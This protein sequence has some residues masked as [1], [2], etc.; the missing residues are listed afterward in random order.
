M[1]AARYQDARA[2]QSRWRNTIRAMRAIDGSSADVSAFERQN[3]INGV[4]RAGKVVC[5]VASC[6]A[7]VRGKRPSRTDLDEMFAKALLIFGNGQLYGAILTE[8]I[9]ARIRVSPAGDLLT[10]RQILQEILRPGVEW[11]TQRKYSEAA[12]SYGSPNVTEG[13]HKSLDPALRTS[14]EAEYRISVEALF[15]LLLALKEIAE[16]RKQ[17]VPI[18]SRSEIAFRLGE[19]ATARGTDV[20]PF[21]DRLTLPSREGWFDLSDG[22]RSADVDITKFD[23]PH[24]LINRPL[25]ALDRSEN[26]KLML[27]PVLAADAMFY[28][29]S[30]LMEGSLNGSYWIS[31]EARRYAGA[32]G[33]AA[34]D[35]F[36]NDLAARLHAMGMEVIPRCKLP[37]LLNQKV[38]ADLGDID[39]LA[40]TP[41]RGRLWVIE[42]K[43]LRLCR[44]ESE[45]ATRMWDYRG[46]LVI[47]DQG[48][49][50]PDKM[51]RHLRRVTY[52]RERADRLTG[53]LK[54][55]RVPEVL[56]LLIVDSPQPM[57]FHT[58]SSDPDTRSVF[59]DAIDSFPFWESE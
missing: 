1:S 34:G 3:Q 24:S 18:L 25:L 54:L 27:S 38:S 17:P 44:S 53:G 21:L 50:R 40:I 42:A 13:E 37:A 2:E 7:P 29:L 5:E 31:D 33:K 30:G 58:L 51:L 41:D 32:Q 59:L 57:N 8:L 43:R 26:P 46:V 19:R 12:L 11:F 55:P 22:L 48:R 9:P 47:D 52:L 20:L 36:E 16:E 10:E 35:K 15:D 23:R 6:E 56:G 4:M 14:L 45:T 39:I 28:S 49:S